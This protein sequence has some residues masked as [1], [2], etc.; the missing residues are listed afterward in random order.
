MI[1]NEGYQ[2]TSRLFGNLNGIAL[3]RI[4]V[5]RIWRKKKKMPPKYINSCVRRNIGEIWILNSP[6]VL[7]IQHR[8]YHVWLHKG[9]V[10]ICNYL[11][12]T[13]TDFSLYNEQVGRSCLIRHSNTVAGLKTIWLSHVWWPAWKI[14]FHI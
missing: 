1:D 10:P 13:W 9:F 7:N 11:E 8:V 14:H 6:L 4:T 2:Q 5:K 3:G 12:N